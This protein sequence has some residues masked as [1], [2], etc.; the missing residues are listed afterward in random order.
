MCAF[1]A[2]VSHNLTSYSAS[3]SI[4]NQNIHSGY[5][6]VLFIITSYYKLSNIY[7]LLTI[8]IAPVKILCAGLFGCHAKAY[9]S[10]RTYIVVHIRLCSADK[11]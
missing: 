10:I 6:F 9:T 2:V 7:C 4:Y 8:I 11:R 3:L 1:I 5:P